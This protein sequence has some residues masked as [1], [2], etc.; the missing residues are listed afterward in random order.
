LSA[1]RSIPFQRTEKIHVPHSLAKLPSN[2]FLRGM[3]RHLVLFFLLFAGSSWT[4][5]CQTLPYTLTDYIPAEEYDPAVPTPK[6]WL[7]YEVGEWH[8]THDQ[9][10]GYM[11]ELART[12]PRIRIETYGYTHERRPLVC[13]TIGTPDHLSRSEEIRAA[14]RMLTEPDRSPNLDP[15][16]FPSVVFMGYSIHGN[17]ASGANAAMLVAYRLAASKS[18]VIEQM[19]SNTII[20]LDP[21]FN[22]DGVQRFASWVNSRRS[23][24]LRTDSNDDEFNEHWPGGRTNHYWFDLNRDWLPLAQP[25]SVGRVKIFQDWRPNILTDHHEMG[26]NATFFFQPGVPSRVNPITPDRNQ[27]LTAAVA[28]YHARTLSQRKVA[29]Y[30]GENY[31][32]FYYGKGSTYPDANGC[33][34]ILFEQGSSRGSAQETDN[35]LLTFAYSIQNQV[36]TSFSTL[37]AAHEMRVELNT[38]L[39]DFYT[40]ALVEARR[41]SE[42]G[43]VVEMKD[44]APDLLRVLLAHRIEVYNL[45]SAITANGTTFTPEKAFWVPKEQPQYRLIKAIFERQ[46]AFEDSIFYDISAWTMPDAYGLRW[47]TLKRGQSVQRGARITAVPAAT[48]ASN[49]SE[50]PTDTYAWLIPADATELPRLLNQLHRRNIRVKVANQPFK[51]EDGTQWQAGTLAILSDRQAIQQ[52]TVDELLERS[53]CPFQRIKNGLTPDGPDLGSN[54]FVLSRPTKILVISGEGASPTDLG[55]L[56]HALDVTW[57]LSPTVV[58]AGRLGQVNLSKYTTIV[59]GDGNYPLLPAEKLKTFINEGGTLV[60][61]GTAMRWLKNNEVAPFEF[62]IADDPMLRNGR[63]PYGM[64]ADDNAARQLSGAIFKAQLDRTHPLCYGYSQ[65][66]LPIFIAEALFLQPSANVYNTPVMLTQD[67]LLAGYVHASQRPVLS[68]AAGVVVQSVGRGRV[69]GFGMNPCFRGFWH[70]TS[71]LFANAVQFGHLIR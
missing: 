67:P 30:S 14:R 63:R 4:L 16:D 10:L 45:Q 65:A 52:T 64:R 22:P 12:S 6:A 15:A 27:Q 61:T 34:G 53:E 8:V 9:L 69:I 50:R 71:R 13:L 31:D 25:E 7:G 35:G 59:L 19:L 2:R 70:G 56:W 28:L 46:T 54:N 40:T 18:A 26:S 57:G 32:D 37:Q 60:A 20:L 49:A 41:D 29:F 43:Y 39:R 38:W 48:P 42:Q 44:R 68:G 5:K 23:A 17:E 11:R 36:L 3:K 66:E 47:A 24:T 51:T 55:E 58:E 21:C 1:R 33:L 62:R